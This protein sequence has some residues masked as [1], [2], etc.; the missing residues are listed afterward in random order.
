MHHLNGAHYPYMKSALSDIAS[1]TA[2]HPFRGS[3]PVVAN[4]EAR[5]VQIRDLDENGQIQWDQLI[6][7]DIKGRKQP[8]WLQM[9]DILFSA[10][11]Q[12]NTAALVDKQTPNTLCAPHYFIIRVKDKRIEPAFLAWQLNQAPAQ[13]Y[14]SISSQGSAVTSIPRNLLAATPITIPSIEKQ[15]VIIAIAKTH[16][17]EK[18][19]LKAL[20]K[21]R[22]TQMQALVNDLMLQETLSSKPN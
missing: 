4:G 9:G 18:S 19:L 2:G 7:T 12:R 17:R 8:D 11:G 6:S 22:D 13:K 15:A 20:I 16:L 3:I 1:I 21:N 10:R 5:V 14:F